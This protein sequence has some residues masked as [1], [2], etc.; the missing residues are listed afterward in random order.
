MYVQETKQKRLTAIFQDTSKISVSPS[1][2]T[3]AQRAKY[4]FEAEKPKLAQKQ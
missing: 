1:W 2:L 3:L 4:H